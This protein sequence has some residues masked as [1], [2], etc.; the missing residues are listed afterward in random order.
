MISVDF[1]HKLILYLFPLLIVLFNLL[2]APVK[3]LHGLH[4]E[5]A[6]LEVSR[7]LDG[8]AYPA[9]ACLLAVLFHLLI[10]ALGLVELLLALLEAH[11]FAPQVTQSFVQLGL[12][13]VN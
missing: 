7:V 2:L 11:G 9:F 5:P 4:K 3:L 10:N 12:V 13:L 8:V 1:V 6:L